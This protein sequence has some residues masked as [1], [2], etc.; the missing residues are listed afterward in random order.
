[1]LLLWSFLF[2]RGD[3]KTISILHWGSQAEHITGLRNPGSQDRLKRGTQTSQ[4]KCAPP[5]RSPENHQSCIYCCGPTVNVKTAW[6]EPSPLFPIPLVKCCSLQTLDTVTESLF[7]AYA[8]S[9]CPPS[10]P[11]RPVPYFPDILLWGSKGGRGAPIRAL[12]FYIC[13]LFEVDITA[14]SRKLDK[15]QLRVRAEHLTTVEGTDI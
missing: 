3:C 9:S 11:L 12:Q 5:L 10:V 1:M 6:G 2:Y 8:P 14:C 7:Q 13:I 15:K 4:L